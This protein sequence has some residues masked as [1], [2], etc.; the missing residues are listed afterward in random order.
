MNE[1]TFALF[2][3]YVD[4]KGRKEVQAEWM[5][6]KGPWFSILVRNTFGLSAFKRK[7]K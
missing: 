6:C 7:K 1:E 3:A 4:L 5:E 2:R